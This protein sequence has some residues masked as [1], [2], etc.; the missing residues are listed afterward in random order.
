MIY[1]LVYTQRAVRD[2]NRLDAGV[3]KR[4]E[5][6]VLQAGRLKFSYILPQKAQKVTALKAATP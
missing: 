2:I 5:F 3:K 4:H 6:Y 1:R